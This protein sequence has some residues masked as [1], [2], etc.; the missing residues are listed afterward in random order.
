[1]Y[2]MVFFFLEKSCGAMTE[3]LATMQQRNNAA[4]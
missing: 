4:A 1:M 3:A 2:G